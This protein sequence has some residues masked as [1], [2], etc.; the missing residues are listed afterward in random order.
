MPG[1]EYLLSKCRVFLL[2]LLFYGRCW[3]R[4]LNGMDVDLE[5]TEH[6]F[7]QRGETKL[8]KKKPVTN[9]DKCP[10]GM[11]QRKPGGQDRVT[12]GPS[13]KDSKLRILMDK[14]EQGRVSGTGKRQARALGQGAARR[15]VQ[16]PEKRAV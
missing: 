7:Q 10:K 9:R 11:G 14:K 2:S 3:V 13:K 16:G 6:T 1:M 15:S 5:L 4:A 12:E 8:V